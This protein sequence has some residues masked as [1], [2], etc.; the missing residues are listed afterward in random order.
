MGTKM[1]VLQSQFRAKPNKFFD[2][3]WPK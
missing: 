2:R 1:F 3:C